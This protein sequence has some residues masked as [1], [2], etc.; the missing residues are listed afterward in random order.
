LSLPADFTVSGSPVTTTGTLTAVR[1]SQSANLFLAS[2]NGASGVPSYRAIVAADVPTLN[3][4]TTGTAGGL[5][6]TALTGDV[7]NSGNTITL[8]NT[9]V[10]AGSY[11]SANITVDAKG[12]LTAASNGSG[13]GGYYWGFTLSNDGTTPNTVLDI[14]AG[15]Q[16]DSTWST[17]I[18]GTAFTKTTGGTWVAGTGN[19]GMGTGLT[20]AAS[21]WYHVFAIIHSGSYDVYFDTSTTAANAPAG[22][23]AHR[24]I[25]SILTDASAHIMPFIQEGQT[26]YWTSAQLA[27]SGG[28]AT[29]HTLVTVASPYGFVT[30][31]LAAPGIT[32][33]SIN[34]SIAIYHDSSS[35]ISDILLNAAD[36]TNN[37]TTR[38][39][40]L[41]NTTSQVYYAVSRS[42]DSGSLFVNGYINPHVAP[43][44]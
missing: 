34:D 14:S 25:G 41:T 21:T 26:F 30:T 5:T 29:T 9:A 20:V 35:N 17:Q 37:W 36:A 6:G 33:S 28:T 42:T 39:L 10:T 40:A 24:Y 15:S 38:G 12:R 2:P 19:A 31:I 7:T 3:Q 23:T 22:T 16:P 1:A 32:A 4:N 43:V 8:A 44:F 11:T 13:G 18:T 27:L